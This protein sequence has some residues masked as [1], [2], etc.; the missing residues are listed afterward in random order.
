[1][2]STVAKDFS[3]FP[4]L[5]E[6]CLGDNPYLQMQRIGEGQLCKVCGRPFTVYR[7]KPG[8]E[9]RY[10]KT[11]ICQ[12]CA[13]FKHVCQCCVL[14]LQFGLPVAVRD[15]IGGVGSEGGDG[16]IAP[17]T[18]V[19]KEFHAVELERK[20]DD[21][22]VTGYGKIIAKPGLERVSRAKPYYERNKPYVCGY[23]LKG[24]CTRGDSCPYRHED[25][26]YDPELANQDIRKRYHG[27]GD[28][29]AEKM[30]KHIEKHRL[31]PDAPDDP[32]ITTLYVGNIPEQI[33]E[34][35][36]RLHLGSYGDIED[37]KIIRRKKCGFVTFVERGSA[38]RAANSVGGFF[39]IG[40]VKDLRLLW[41]RPRETDDPA[42]GTLGGA[43]RIPV[44]VVGPKA[45]EKQIALSLKDIP[46]PPPPGSKGA[47]KTRYPSQ[48][49]HF[50][51]TKEKP[52]EKSKK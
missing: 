39:S 49:P 19:N 42:A 21:E 5:C 31:V 50:F 25:P 16:M 40:D 1:M 23:W 41:A 8:T 44:G 45:T 18:S 20:M 15:A 26:G 43:S 46:I 3:D 47:K 4:I 28:V 13:K 37:V 32:S 38:E 17:V 10:K 52:S 12:A 35:D 14:D 51:G 9:A 36:L 34:E 24:K 6:V 33:G 22:G 11:Q 7:W 27:R 2:S 48:N 30:L 29:V